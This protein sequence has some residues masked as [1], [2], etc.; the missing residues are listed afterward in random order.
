MIHIA[1]WFCKEK[2]SAIKLVFSQLTED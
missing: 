2:T 1:V